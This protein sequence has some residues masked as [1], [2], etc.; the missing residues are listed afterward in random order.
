[1]VL[2][3]AI[4][5]FA[6]KKNMTKYRVAKNSGLSQTTFLDV[7]NGKNTNPKINTLN[8]I[9]KGLGISVSELIKSAE[10]ISEEEN[11]NE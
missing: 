10:D 4:L 1:M 2:G 3:D 6:N 8:K 7:V 5:D 11:K 9:A